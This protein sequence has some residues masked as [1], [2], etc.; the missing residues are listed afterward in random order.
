MTD[1]CFS[2]CVFLKALKMNSQTRNWVSPIIKAIFVAADN[3]NVTYN[4]K[5]ISGL[6][7]KAI[8]EVVF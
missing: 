4:E 7:K 1:V 8:P 6:A 5:K 3:Y 2:G